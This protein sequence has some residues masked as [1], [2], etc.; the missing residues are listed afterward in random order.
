MKKLLVLTLFLFS[1]L[2]FAAPVETLDDMTPEQEKRY[3][4]LIAELRCLV[5]MNQSLADSNAELAVDMRNEV[6]K[7]VVSGQANQEIVD[8]LVERYGDFV[9]YR[10]PVNA[11]TVLLWFGPLILLVIGA[12]VLIKNNKKKRATASLSEEQ[13]EKAKRLLDTISE[14]NNS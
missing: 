12:I 7:K 4:Q 3:R 5:C 10:P 13:H 11:T 2:A 8:F 14:E 9:R 6:H 1:S